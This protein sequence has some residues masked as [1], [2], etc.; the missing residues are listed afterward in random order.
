[1]EGGMDNYS[2]K[3]IFN[4]SHGFSLVMLPTRPGHVIQ[5]Y[6]NEM[7]DIT[8]KLVVYLATGF[9]SEISSHDVAL[10]GLKLAL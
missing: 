9:V 1:M 3:K 5:P 8:A 7:T 10:I 6:S 4:L 2:L